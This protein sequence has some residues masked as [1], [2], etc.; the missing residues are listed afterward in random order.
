MLVLYLARDLTDRPEVP[1]PRLKRTCIR[2]LRGPVGFGRKKEAPALLILLL[3]EGI[4][5]VFVLL[6]NCEPLQL[7]RGT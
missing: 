3:V 6:Q 1:A 7:H 2:S 5:D 4:D